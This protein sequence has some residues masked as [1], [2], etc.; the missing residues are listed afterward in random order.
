MTGV[1]GWT[2]GARL[3]AVMLFASL[4]PMLVSMLAIQKIAGDT[5]E[6]QAVTSLSAQRDQ[7]AR[8][9]TGLIHEVQVFTSSLAE[10]LMVVT[11]LRSFSA[12]ADRLMQD[13]PPTPQEIAAMRGALEAY[14]REHQYDRGNRTGSSLTLPTDDFGI[15][16]QYH[17]LVRNPLGVERKHERV[18]FDELGTY[19]AMHVQYHPSLTRHIERH[20]Y[21]DLSLIDTQGRVVYTV[22][23]NIDVGANVL[24]GALKDSGLGR[25][26]ARAMAA[27]SADLVAIS[28]FEFYFPAGNEATAFYAAPVIDG[29]GR[30]L[31]VV[32]LQIRPALVAQ[33]LEGSMRNLR[34]G[35]MYIVGSDSMLRTP[36]RQR[37]GSRALS[38]QIDHAGVANALRGDT[39]VVTILGH[40]GKSQHA[41]FV[42][43]QSSGFK[44]ALV[45][46]ADEAEVM[47]MVGTLRLTG[48]IMMIVTVGVVLAMALFQARSVRNQLGGEPRDLADMAEKMASGIFET[49]PRDSRQAE[50]GAGK[51]LVAMK[52]RLSEIIENIRTSA[53]NVENGAREIAN[54]NVLLSQRTEDQASHLQITAGNMNEMT[55]TV[56]FN[57]RHANVA[58]ALAADARSEVQRGVAA[59]DETVNAMS[60]I[61]RSSQEIAEITSVIDEIA[62]QTNLLALNAAVEAA[63]AGEHGRGFAVV[64]T[65][66]RTLAQR[67]AAAAREIK[68]LIETSVEKV[69]TGSRLVDASGLTLRAILKAV[70]KVNNIVSEIAQAG[71]AQLA[72][73]E[74]VNRSV[75]GMDAM[76]QQNAELVEQVAAASE[77][78]GVEARKLNTLLG[79]FRLNSP[80]IGN[81]DLALPNAL[82]TNTPARRPAARD[83]GYV[84][85]RAGDGVRK[86][87]ADYSGPE[88]RSNQRPWNGQSKVAPKVADNKSVS[89]GDWTEF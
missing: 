8:Q 24:S 38:T 57:T 3:V 4:V 78:M 82:G 23:K 25:V 55:D 36:S 35:D 7:Y 46:S 69:A 56:Q 54:G 30:R 19:G 27:A 79:Y 2:F 72:G 31:G 6:E 44:W 53:A 85:L 15:I 32:A 86:R 14:Y 61:N 87:V 70:D 49:S 42:P 37:E 43:L 80:A 39:G 17:M 41:A 28:D 83:D 60:E 18:E 74:S 1:Q 81:R 88:R 5:L 47:A 52:C 21:T 71:D 89:N 50:S 62:F 73:I 59:V 64:A 65:E 22:R 63:H 40:D 33:A 29:F 68:A 13:L 9:I 20:N 26:V 66:V 77:A 76:T 58:S 84:D 48:A 51:A 45:A 12:E 34:S 67:S 11:A 75:S 16:A 10:D